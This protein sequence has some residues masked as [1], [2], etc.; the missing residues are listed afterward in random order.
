M[1]PEWVVESIEKQHLQPWQNYRLV[2]KSSK[3]KELLFNNEPLIQNEWQRS[4]STN[5]PEFI[6][7]YYE[8]S[9]LHYLS[10]WK[11]E[12][13]DIV[14]KLQLKY[15]KSPYQIKRKRKRDET[16]VIM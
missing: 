9:R 8:T 1:R 12:L 4:V 2:S 16:R 3:Q 13:K 15:P 14:D 7:R 11:S 5:N 10:T 6:K